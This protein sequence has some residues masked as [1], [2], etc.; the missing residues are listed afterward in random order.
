LRSRLEKAST[1]LPTVAKKF[2]LL[3]VDF[4]ADDARCFQGRPSS[5]AASIRF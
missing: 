4:V 3:P 1:N 2:P 5:L